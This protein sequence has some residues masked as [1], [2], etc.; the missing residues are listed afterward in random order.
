MK[1]HLIDGTFELFRAH[2]AAPSMKAP[3]GKEV[4][5][6]RILLRILWKLLRSPGVTHVGIAFD[7]V[8]ESFRNRLFAGYKTGEGIEPELYAQF[9]LAEE[10]ARALG[11]V[12]WPMVKF[13]ADDAMASACEKFKVHP[14]VKQ[15]VLCSPDKDLCQLVEGKK[16]VCLDRIRESTLD[17]T[18]VKK[19]FGVSPGSIPDYLA[20]VG[21]TADGIPGIERWGSKS[22]SLVLAKFKTIEAI[23]DSHE[24]WLLLI[25]GGE[26]LAAA[27]NENKNNALLF[28]KLATLRRD[29]PLK[30]K[31]T[32]LEWRGPN[33]AKLK[34]L[35]AQLGDTRFI[36]AVQNQNPTRSQTQAQYLPEKSG[37]KSK[38]APKR[39][40]VLKR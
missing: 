12:T 22:A 10:C 33:I 35:C 26:R 20:L 15:I 13:E 5:A 36:E 18:G 3:D 23:P 11:I 37:A 31:L 19:K 25:R 40:A 28:K 24:S 21:D 1:V 7:K 6:T 39:L 32:D 14:K 4:G 27:L 8:I 16:V 30:E 38:T 34:K 29:V 2:F 9:P 17:D